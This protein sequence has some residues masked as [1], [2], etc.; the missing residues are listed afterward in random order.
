MKLEIVQLESNSDIKTI[1]SDKISKSSEEPL[2]SQIF[3]EQI[4]IIDDQIKKII[5]EIPKDCAEPEM[6]KEENILVNT[7]T[8]NHVAPIVTPTP[9]RNLISNQ[10]PRHSDPL[11][12]H[13]RLFVWPSFPASFS[14]KK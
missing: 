12:L 6:I 1:E 2:K 8:N 3:A 7:V 10:P 13:R 5:R 4:I 9:T 14:N 11:N